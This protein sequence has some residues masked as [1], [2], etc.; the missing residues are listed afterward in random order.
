MLTAECYIF[1]NIPNVGDVILLVYSK[2]LTSDMKML[3]YF[4]KIL[5]MLASVVLV[6]IQQNPNLAYENAVMVCKKSVSLPYTTLVK[7]F[8]PKLAYT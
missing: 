6:Y 4:F 8:N 3:L 5:L 2:T 1:L 7:D